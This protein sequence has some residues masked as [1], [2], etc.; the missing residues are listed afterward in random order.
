MHRLMEGQV[1][2]PRVTWTPRELCFLEIV[3][4][5]P[6]ALVRSHVNTQACSR[7]K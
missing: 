7:R 4:Q 2:A 3:S 1:N 6:S 5:Q